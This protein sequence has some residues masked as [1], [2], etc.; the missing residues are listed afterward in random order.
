MQTLISVHLLSNH[1]NIYENQLNYKSIT[2]ANQ[3]LTNI[4]N[5]YN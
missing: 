3:A 2:I 1:V 5:F 4:A